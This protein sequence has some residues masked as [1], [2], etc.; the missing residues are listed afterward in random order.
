MD[1]FADKEKDKRKMENPFLRYRVKFKI[2]EKLFQFIIKLI[3][4]NEQLNYSLYQ[5]FLIIDK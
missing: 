3:I 2:R 1:D 5:I 4:I